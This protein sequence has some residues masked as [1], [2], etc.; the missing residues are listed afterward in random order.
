MTTKTPAD[1]PKFLI[2][3][4]PIEFRIGFIVF[5]I[6]LSTTSIFIFGEHSLRQALLFFTASSGSAA[7]IA[8]AVYI[9][10]TL[11]LTSE[12]QQKTEI[13]NKY[14]QSL[15]QN[16]QE[17]TKNLYK[18]LVELQKEKQVKEKKEATLSY[19]SRWNNDYR[20]KLLLVKTMTE[21][22]ALNGGVEK[23]KYIEEKLREPEIK[24]EV[25]AALSFFEEIAFAIKEKIVYESM[26]QD[27]FTE[28]LR[29]YMITFGEW[30][31]ERRV[32]IK[33]PRIYIESTKLNDRWT[34]PE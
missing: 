29:D 12:S 6:V 4:K 23:R 26:L 20:N 22:T 3:L 33:S 27:F 19:I 32:E 9:G 31:T 28:V 13:Q 7:G 21:Y 24:T 17:Q 30:I 34:M 1:L 15:E 2:P 16:F 25:I 5:V 11:K 8:S 14:R 18:E 10:H